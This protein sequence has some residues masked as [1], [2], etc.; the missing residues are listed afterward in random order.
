MSGT[1]LLGVGLYFIL[2]GRLYCWRI[3]ALWVL[4]WSK[5]NDRHNI[6]LT[7]FCMPNKSGIIAKGIPASR[8]FFVKVNIK[9]TDNPN[10]A[11]KL[12]VAEKQKFDIIFLF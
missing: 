4:L 8:L 5:R 9:T 12:A 2:F 1:T 3:Y 11:T 6:P 10:P 7:I